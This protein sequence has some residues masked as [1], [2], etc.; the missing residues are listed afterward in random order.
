MIHAPYKLRQEAHKH[1][2]TDR[3]KSS[4]TC[5]HTFFYVLYKMFFPTEKTSYCSVKM[6][7]AR[8]LTIVRLTLPPRSDGAYCF[9]ARLQLTNQL[10]SSQWGLK[11]RF[12]AHKHQLIRFPQRRNGRTQAL[13]LSFFFPLFLWEGWLEQRLFYYFGTGKLMRL[14]YCT[15]LPPRQTHWGQEEEKTRRASGK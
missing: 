1:T 13:Y 12:W 2:V 7:N 5:M 10:K 14:V 4:S 8:S 11:R 6:I 15:V 9:F 3:H